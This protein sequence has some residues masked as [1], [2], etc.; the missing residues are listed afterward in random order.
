[1]LSVSL[2]AKRYEM[3]SKKDEYERG[4]NDKISFSLLYVEY[5]AICHRKGWFSSPFF[6]FFF[7]ELR[8]SL[9]DLAWQ[10]PLPPLPNNLDTRRALTSQKY[11]VYYTY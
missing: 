6:S 8:S 1:M 10:S 4:G 2:A 9:Y 7:S 11:I 5:Y 3:L